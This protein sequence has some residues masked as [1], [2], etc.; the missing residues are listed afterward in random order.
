MSGDLQTA[1][2]GNGNQLVQD[3]VFER[4]TPPPRRDHS[5]HTCGSHLLHLSGDYRGIGAAVGATDGVEVGADVV[6]GIVPGLFPVSP[7]AVVILTGVPGVVED[8]DL[9]G[10]GGRGDGGSG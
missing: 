5:V 2:C 10:V 4:T 1:L 8:G 3:L 9:G 6:S 7:A